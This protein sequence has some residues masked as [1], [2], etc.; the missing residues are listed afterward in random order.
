MSLRHFQIKRRTVEKYG[1]NKTSINSREIPR[2][3]TFAEKKL[4]SRE[5]YTKE[6]LLH[7]RRRV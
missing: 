3:D 7:N 2:T 5:K 4:N 6:K 1:A